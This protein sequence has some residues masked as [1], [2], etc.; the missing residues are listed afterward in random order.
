M[1]IRFLT[2][3]SIVSGTFAFICFSTFLLV[4]IAQG[5]ETLA[6]L[7]GITAVI[8]ISLPLIFFRKLKMWMKLI[9]C[10]VM[11]VYMLTFFA[12]CFFLFSYPE[13]NVVEDSDIIIMVYGCR[14][15]EHRPSKALAVRLDKAYELLIYYPDA[16]CIVS[17]GQ[18]PNEPITEAFS[19]KRYLMCKGIDGDRIYMEP[20]SH[21]TEENITKTKELIER[22]N[23]ED[24]KII[25]VSSDYHLRRIKILCD[26]AGVETELA[27][28]HSRLS[29]E[30]FQ[31]IVREY[32]SYIKMGWN[33]VLQ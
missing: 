19:M 20:D 30:L 26:K 28:A 8:A 22:E 24:Y 1:R 31:N 3:L 14:T 33:Y 5:G 32:M 10:V 6:V 17:G 12:F 23:L 7:I 9:F 27:P 16:L 11:S 13:P 21:N 18:G 15:Y 4:S 29:L 25:G 2:I